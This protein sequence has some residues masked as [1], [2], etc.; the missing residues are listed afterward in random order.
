[1]KTWFLPRRVYNV[2]GHSRRMYKK[3]TITGAPCLEPREFR[4]EPVTAL[5]CCLA[6]DWVLDRHRIFWTEG[7]IYEQR[8]GGKAMDGI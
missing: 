6:L 8:Q 4:E 2:V 7:P 5:S 3:T 1:M